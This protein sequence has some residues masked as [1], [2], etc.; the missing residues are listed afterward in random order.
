VLRYNAVPAKLLL[1]ICNLNN[2]QDRT[3]I[4]TRDFRQQVAEA[5]ADALVAYYGTAA[6]PPALQTTTAAR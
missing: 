5:V 1:E 2:P 3:L 4:Q 6:A